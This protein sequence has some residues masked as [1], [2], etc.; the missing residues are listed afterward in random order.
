[1]PYR[2]QTKLKIESWNEE[3]KE[4]DDGSK[5]SL[6]DTTLTGEDEI[7]AATSYSAMFYRADRTCSMQIVIRLEATLQGR[8]GSF[9]LAGPGV[10]DGTTA[11]QDLRV[12]EQSATGDLAGITGSATSSSRHEDYPHMPLTLEYDLA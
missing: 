9:V 5:M 8:R 4:F 2:T 3:T 6:A 7:S 12:V 11:T 10:Y 1:M